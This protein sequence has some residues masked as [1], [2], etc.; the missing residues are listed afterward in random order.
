MKLYIAPVIEDEHIEEKIEKKLHRSKEKEYVAQYNKERY[1]K[2]RD[3]L[4]AIM[5]R[6]CR[7]RI[8]ECDIVYYN[9]DMHKRSKKHKNNA[10]DMEFDDDQVFRMH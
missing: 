4:L 9:K 8:C 5:A 7:C 1:L 10:L 3:K 6:K 2:N